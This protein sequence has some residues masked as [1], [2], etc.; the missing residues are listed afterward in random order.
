[1]S[2]LTKL[3]LVFLLASVLLLGYQGLSKLMGT[4]QMGSDVVWDGLTLADLIG[5]EEDGSDTAAAFS[6][7]EGIK[8]FFLN[9][10]MFLWLLGL[11]VICFLLHAFSK[12]S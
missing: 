8:T 4:D 11:A 2:G 6:S 10:P 9:L 7:I 1:M 3:G 5:G 12:P